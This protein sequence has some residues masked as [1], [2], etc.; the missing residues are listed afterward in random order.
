M[1]L[2]EIDGGQ[3]YTDEGKEKDMQRDDYMAS[4]GLKVLRFSDR[5]VFKNLKKVMEKIG[6]NL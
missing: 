3:H 6:G 2:I 5:E 4:L 1:C